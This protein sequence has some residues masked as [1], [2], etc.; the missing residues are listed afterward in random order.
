[1]ANRHRSES[2]ELTRVPSACHEIFVSDITVRII[3]Q[4]LSDRLGQPFIIENRPGGSTSIAIRAEINLAPDGYTLIS[5]R[6]RW[7]VTPQSR[8]ALIMVGHSPSFTAER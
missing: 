6:M 1:M 3:A 2:A 8:A 5:L 4:W 7:L